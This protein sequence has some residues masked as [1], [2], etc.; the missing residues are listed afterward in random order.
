MPGGPSCAAQDGPGSWLHVV[1]WA[2]LTSITVLDRKQQQNAVLGSRGWA[3]AACS[4]DGNLPMLSPPWPAST[5]AR[6]RAGCAARDPRPQQPPTGAARGLA[7]RPAR[8]SPGQGRWAPGPPRPTP[9][10]PP[11]GS[12]GPP[13]R[14]RSR[15]LSARPAPP[16]PLNHTPRHTLRG[17]WF[18]S[19]L[20][21]RR[22]GRNSALRVADLR[23]VEHRRSSSIRCSTPGALAPVRVV[24]SRSIITYSAPSAP[25]AGTPRFPGRAGY[26]RRLRCA[27]APRRPASGSVLS[28]PAPSRHAIFCDPGEPAD[29]IRPVPSP[30]ARAFALT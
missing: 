1:V 26:T 28:L 21:A 13:E 30:A 23:S 12:A 14:R 8:G 4:T 2:C 25:L 10:R 11:A 22:G 19:T 17:T 29:C 5:L 20:R 18:A 16:R 3:F 6:R 9:R 24:V 27:G 15:L 7:P